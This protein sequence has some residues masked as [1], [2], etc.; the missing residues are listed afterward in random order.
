[1]IIT[2]IENNKIKEL[3]KLQKKK[4]RDFTNSYLV[5]TKHLVDEAYKA[6]LVDELFLLEKEKCSY[7]VKCTYVSEAVMRKI[8]TTDTLCS[9]VGLCHK[10]INQE[11][12]GDKILLLDG[13][14]DPGNLGTIIRS[15]VAFNVTTIVLSLDTVDLYNPKVLRSAQ[16]NDCHINICIRDLEEVIADLKNNNYI[17][18]GTNV[19]NGIDVRSLTSKD[20][21]KYCL[22]VGNE[23][24]GIKSNIQEMC[25]NFLYITMNNE[26]ESLNVGV[27]CSILLY[28]LER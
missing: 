12:I 26:V 21:E 28:E 6:G 5:E 20:K 11:I 27:A 13:I 7:D 19:T 17:I 2:S 1:M 8:S 3:I 10:R 9:M 25:D 15:A 23:G 22:I 18:Y 24:H 16:G 4:Y 14:Q